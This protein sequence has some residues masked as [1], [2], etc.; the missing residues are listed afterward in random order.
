MVAVG[1]ERVTAIGSS[2][3]APLNWPRSL[4]PSPEPEATSS[5]LRR[6]GC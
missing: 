3:T 5:T 1:Q 4:W 2:A 6:A